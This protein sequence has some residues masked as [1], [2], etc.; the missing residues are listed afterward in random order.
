MI[1]HRLSL[2]VTNTHPGL[3]VRGGVME[4]SSKQ[5]PDFSGDSPEIV[6]KT[7]PTKFCCWSVPAG[8]SPQGLAS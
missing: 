1:L 5:Q 8:K 7:L 6:R 3:G 2:L 4:A